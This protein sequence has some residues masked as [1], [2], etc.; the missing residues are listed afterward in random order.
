MPLS[1]NASGSRGVK[2]GQTSGCKVIC[3]NRNPWSE[4]SLSWQFILSVQIH[5]SCS[6]LYFCIWL[7]ILHASSVS[8]S[9]LLVIVLVRISFS[10]S[11]NRWTNNTSIVNLKR[12]FKDIS[13]CHTSVCAQND[14]LNSG[15]NSMEPTWLRMG[16]VPLTGVSSYFWRK[17]SDMNLVTISPFG[18]G[19]K[20]KRIRG[21]SPIVSANFGGF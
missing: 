17:H 15:I 5:L 3:K 18:Q 7:S 19:S 14:L 6:R 12:W 8:I 11:C 21:W 9:C 1:S 16:G 10:Q 13:S 2:D 4:L 20:C